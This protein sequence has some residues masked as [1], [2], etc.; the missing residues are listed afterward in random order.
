MNKNKCKVCK[1]ELVFISDNT[2]TKIVEEIRPAFKTLSKVHDG[3][4]SLCPECDRYALGAEMERGYPFFD[5]NG[6]KQTLETVCSGEMNEHKLTDMLTSGLDIVF[7]GTAVG[8]KSAQNN[9]YYGNSSNTFWKVLA[10]TGLTNEEITPEHYKDLIKYKIGLT[11][12][13]KSESGMDKDV[14]LKDDTDIAILKYKVLKYTPYILVFTSK[15]AAKV[16]FQTK[17]VQYGLQSQSI[18]DT[19]IYVCPSTSGAARG[20]FDIQYWNE[21]KSLLANS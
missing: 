13:N 11:D 18:G 10:Q 14:D 5:S 21:L 16:F 19:K 20:H 3:I 2:Y 12:I 6:T 8:N 15:E 4:Y 1:S 17:N 9:A 7:C